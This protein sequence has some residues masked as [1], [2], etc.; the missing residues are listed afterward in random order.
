MNSPSSPRPVL[1]IVDDDENLLRAMR[2][3][4]ERAG[5]QVFAV[6]TAES[7]KESR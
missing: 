6:T 1:L 3:T 7:R 2:R 4:T 5:Y